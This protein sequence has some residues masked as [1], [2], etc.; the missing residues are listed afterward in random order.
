MTETDTML[1]IG[2]MEDIWHEMGGRD[3][4]MDNR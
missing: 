3:C 1:A 4:P 2:I